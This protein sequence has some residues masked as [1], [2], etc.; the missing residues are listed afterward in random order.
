MNYLEKNYS[1]G[2]V[3][4]YI[5]W[6]GQDYIRFELNRMPTTQLLPQFALQL[7]GCEFDCAI[8]GGLFK[9]TRGDAIMDV[10]VMDGANINENSDGWKN[11]V[12]DIV[13]KSGIE[14]NAIA[15]STELAINN[16]HLARGGNYYHFEASNVEDPK[17]T[18]TVVMDNSNDASI[19]AA[20]ALYDEHAARTMIGVRRS[21]EVVFVVT[22]A[23]INGDQQLQILKDLNC[24]KAV[25]L[26]GSY[27][28]DMYV[29][30][31]KIP[32]NTR[33]IRDAICCYKIKG[34]LMLLDGSAARI[35]DNVQGNILK[36]VNKTGIISVNDFYDW[37]AGDGYRWCWGVGGTSAASTTGAFQYDPAVM[38]PVG[39]TESGNLYMHLESSA[40]R[41]RAGVQGTILT[42]VPK[43]TDIVIKEFLPLKASDGYYWCKGQYGS[44]VGYFQYDPAVM[45]PHGN[46]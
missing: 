46:V 34:V 6:P 36:T 5:V 43:G 20:K 33:P 14:M 24:I 12:L 42:T 44:T 7:P 11:N 26:D 18:L 4:C 3:Y 28:S 40:A 17:K 9:Y 39:I 31:H 23:E 10:A 29:K 25:N 19:K 45:Y 38:H 22:Y 8:N 27:S 21:G 1:F 37:K 13:S 41:I 15:T 32:K 16:Y 2:T 35:R 30:D